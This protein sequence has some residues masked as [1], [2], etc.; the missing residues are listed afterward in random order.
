MTIFGINILFTLFMI[1]LFIWDYK[2]YARGIHKDFKSIIMS[3]GVLGTFVGIFV[4][5][6]EFDTAHLESSVPLLLDGLRF[7]SQSSKSARP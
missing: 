2:S 4:G 6:L 1:G 5:L 3:T 7:C